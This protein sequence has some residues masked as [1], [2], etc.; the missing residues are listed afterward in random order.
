[1]AREKTDFQT[2]GE[3][4]KAQT[5][6]VSFGRSK[7]RH[8][9]LVMPYNYCPNVADLVDESNW[10]TIQTALAEADP[11]GKTYELQRFSSWVTPYERYILKPKSAAL[12]AAQHIMQRYADY[13]ILNEE[14]L[15]ERESAAQYQSVV[16]ELRPLTLER[17][18]EILTAEQTSEL[19]SD[20]C[21]N[22]NDSET[23]S[24]EQVKA[25]LGELDWIEC[26]DDIW[27]PLFET[28]P[29]ETTDFE[30]IP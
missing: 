30:V 28:E 4:L 9:W 3:W 16:D 25:A 1:M 26:V 23:Y 8:K 24:V 11:S 2:Y 27:R 18:G 15:S 14:D 22:S 29:V 19:A 12:A 21:H 7:R 17:N 5:C 20:I 13:Q 10:Q 6:F